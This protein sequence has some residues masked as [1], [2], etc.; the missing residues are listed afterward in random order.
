MIGNWGLWWTTFVFWRRALLFFFPGLWFSVLSSCFMLFYSKDYAK[1]LSIFHS[2]AFSSVLPRVSAQYLLS[3]YDSA[4]TRWRVNFFML[5]GCM[6]AVRVLC[7]REKK[8]TTFS[9]S[10]PLPLAHHIFFFF[11]TF[12]YKEKFN[13]FFYKKENFLFKQ[14]NSGTLKILTV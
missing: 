14:N 1:I 2:I 12:L 7:N 6:F 4:R 8:C 11:N 10:H 3:Y 5:V 13:F 9:C